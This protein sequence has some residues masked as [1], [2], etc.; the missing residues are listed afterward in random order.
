M[1]VWVPEIDGQS[2]PVHTELTRRECLFPDSVPVSGQ[3]QL[4]GLAAGRPAPGSQC[5]IR[6]IGIGDAPETL[7]LAIV[8]RLHADAV[9][10]TDLH[11]P[12]CPVPE[13]V[14]ADFPLGHQG[15]EPKL[16]KPAWRTLKCHPQLV[17]A[18]SQERCQI[19][20]VR[21]ERSAELANSLLIEHHTSTVVQSLA[22]EP[23][24][25][26]AGEPLVRKRR[27]I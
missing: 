25:L 13:I 8:D 10:Y 6:P 14:E 23:I 7:Y 15:S 5:A 12:G 4:D 2:S 21:H 27:L 19:E 26:A 9:P 18:W 1:H 3:R 24:R 16:A 11:H 20:H 17:A 22:I